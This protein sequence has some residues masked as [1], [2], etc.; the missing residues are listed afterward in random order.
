VIR[1]GGSA[2]WWNVLGSAVLGRGFATGGDAALTPGYTRRLLLGHEILRSLCGLGRA[3]AEFGAERNN[4]PRWILSQV[5]LVGVLGLPVCLTARECSIGFRYIAPMRFRFSMKWLLAAMVYVAL[6]AAAFTRA[7]SWWADG[8]W[9]VSFLAIV[10][11]C[12]VVIYAEGARRA[13]AGGFLIGA[14]ALLIARLLGPGSTPVG[15]IASVIPTP[16]N[17]TTHGQRIFWQVKA[18]RT[19]DAVAP[20]VAG[21]AG[22]LLVATAYRQCRPLPQEPP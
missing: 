1:P 16:A 4:R 11:S 10:Y 15:R 17:V 7:G 9:L 14:I 3:Q 19:A 18:H 5:A 8:L 12:G 22:S 21:L 6:V 13:R 2:G 20:V